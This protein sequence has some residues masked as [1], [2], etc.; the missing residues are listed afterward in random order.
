MRFSCKK[1]NAKYAIADEKIRGKVVKIRC[2]HCGQV[3]VVRDAGRLSVPP[4]EAPKAG[5]TTS[6]VASSAVA[7]SELPVSLVP[8]PA[9]PQSVAPPSDEFS[10]DGPASNQI[11][12]QGI[13]P[14]AGPSQE[15]AQAF[16]GLYASGQ[17]RTG[18]IEQDDGRGRGEPAQRAPVWYYGLDGAEEGPFTSLEIEERIRLGSITRDHFVW[19]EGLDDWTPVEKTFGVAAFLKKIP[20]ETRDTQEPSAIDAIVDEPRKLAPSS[21]A[22]WFE[23]PLPQ[24]KDDH[25]LPSAGEPKRDRITKAVADDQQQK[26]AEQKRPQAPAPAEDFLADRIASLRDE[27]TEAPVAA[28][29]TT[30]EISTGEHNLRRASERFFESGETRAPPS[31]LLPPSPIVDAGLVAAELHAESLHEEHADSIPPFTEAEHPASSDSAI[32]R[33]AGVHSTGRRISMALIGVLFVVL[34]AGGVLA[35]V[36]RKDFFNNNQLVSD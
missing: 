4:I 27:L 26:R 16:K 20:S 7:K 33:Y 19:R 8:E 9:L 30:R 5:L 6:A 34:M 21:R 13:P 28:V 32:I 12:E 1:C 36:L 11:D 29:S 15:F 10:S 25:R 3:M 24:T 14:E 31:E 35:L 23:E 18:P 22:E 2:K 17:P